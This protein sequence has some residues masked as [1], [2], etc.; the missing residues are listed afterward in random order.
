VTDDSRLDRIERSIREL[1]D[2]IEH[3]E[4]V[5]SD[6][7]APSPDDRLT[8]PT[9]PPVPTVGTAADEATPTVPSAASV[10]EPDGAT[11]HPPTRPPSEAIPPPP[12]PPAGPPIRSAEKTP[13]RNFEQVIGTRIAAI[14]GGLLVALAAAFFA[15]L[16]YD[17]GWIG[18][19]PP[20]VRAVCLGLT[21]AGFIVIA[22]ILRRRFGQAASVGLA[23]AGLGT[24]YVDGWAIGSVLDLVPPA[25]A[26]IAMAATTLVG[27]VVTARFGSTLIGAVSLVA[28]GLAPYLV[29][30]EPSVLAPGLYFTALLVV[31]MGASIVRPHPFVG[32]R[33]ATFAVVGVSAVPWWLG[34]IDAGDF[35]IV[36]LVSFAWWGIVHATS[37]VT[38]ARG[39]D[40]KVG[41]VLN[42]VSTAVIAIPVPISV[43]A[44]GAGPGLG[45]LEGWTVLAFAGASVAMACQF[46]PGLAALSPP[47]PELGRRERC[48]HRLAE[49]AWLEAAV[50]L[51]LAAALLLRGVAL[52]IAW[53]GIALGGV[54]FAARRGSRRAAL[55]A[56]LAAVL[57]QGAGSYMVMRGLVPPYP[58][59]LD[60]TP[61]R[62]A[63][64]VDLWIIAAT[65]AGTVATAIWWPAA[66]DG[67]RPT[68]G[69]ATL[70]C[71]GILPWIVPA[72]MLGAPG[73][74]TL[75]VTAPVIAA[76]IVT[77]RRPDRA[78]WRAGIAWATVA[79]IP[80]TASL[81]LPVVATMDGPRA[82]P[83]WAADVRVFMRDWGGPWITT[84]GLA[85]TQIVFLAAIAGIGRTARIGIDEIDGRAR[86]SM[87]LLPVAAIPLG[88]ALLM[89]AI[90]S[91]RVGWSSWI[92]PPMV[93]ATG[94]AAIL[95]LLV[96][97]RWSGS[98]LASTRW[99][100]WLAGI[101]A[102]VWTV[103]AVISAVVPDLAPTDPPMIVNVRGLSGIGILTALVVTT[104]AVRVLDPRG[105]RIPAATTIAL[106]LALGSVLVQDLAGRGTLA[107]DSG[108]SIWWAVYAIG[109]VVAE[110]RTNLGVLRK[111]GLALLAVTAIKFL[112]ID[113]RNAETI[114]RIISALGVGLLM[115]LT[116]V[117]YVRAFGTPSARAGEQESR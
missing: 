5:M 43:S 12:P 30:G 41:T 54:V 91:T 83:D 95:M 109:L 15:K 53:V 4:S 97:L 104:A 46:G 59:L 34:A 55:F 67:R 100:A 115:V 89:V 33:P 86:A 20:I 101:A 65:G 40:W 13:R 39:L 114:H 90:P 110:F 102:L 29:G 57:A 88:A 8:E 36:L 10:L 45:A 80:M 61:F 69:P 56:G 63:A 70:L 16:A 22:E 93:G 113:L 7:D 58:S 84:L 106:G 92:G 47:V 32:L 82:I 21:G 75:I 42:L 37:L 78:G 38:G 48:R 50:L 105:L 94:A 85:A 19:I 108:I 72:A 44:L 74:W 17:R 96:L 68:R 103:A 18:A 52:P 66:T 24:L 71:A 112:V 49:T 76:A 31:A 107:A 81:A 62:F 51:M 28:G 3:L 77:R 27:L 25:G 64:I 11:T 6:N 111:V 35:T 99:T 116:S 117:I 98:L 23:L 87:R 26:M 14:A 79:L 60:G 9:L 73:W 1:L 2:R